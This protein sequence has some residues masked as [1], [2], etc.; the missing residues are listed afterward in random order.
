MS[1]LAVYRKF[2]LYTN[3]YN[4]IKKLPEPE[5]QGLGHINLSDPALLLLGVAVG[6]RQKLLRKVLVYLLAKDQEILLNSRLRIRLNALFDEDELSAILNPRGARRMHLFYLLESL[7]IATM[8]Q[9]LEHY[10]FSHAAKYIYNLYLKGEAPKIE[11]NILESKLDFNEVID[12]I[13]H[14]ALKIFP[15]FSS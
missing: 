7:P 3:I 12:A 8:L 10:Y 9:H 4:C 6:A 1:Q 13:N 2:K 14:F 15:Q 11:K 5:L